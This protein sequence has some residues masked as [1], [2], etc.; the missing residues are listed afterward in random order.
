M[1]KVTEKFND[2][3]K[4]IES[5]RRLIIIYRWFNEVDASFS[6]VIITALVLA[7]VYLLVQHP[8]DSSGYF[9]LF[10]FSI[11][12]LFTLS[13]LFVLYYFFSIILNTTTITIN[14]KGRAQIKQGPI[15]CP[16]NR[17]VYI[18]ERDYLVIEKQDG[19]RSPSVYVIYVK[20]NRVETCKLISFPEKETTDYVKRKIDNFLS[21]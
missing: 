9:T 5:D 13:S 17:R 4:A 20:G 3:L 21:L 12:T 10:I 1:A 11:V 8:Q 19:Y 15:P 14:K 7:S 2:K 18:M 16:G 6:I